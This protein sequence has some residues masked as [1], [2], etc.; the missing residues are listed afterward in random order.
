MTETMSAAVAPFYAIHRKMR[1]DTRRYVIAIETATEA[2]RSGR[3]VPLAKW[4]AGFGHELHLHHTVEDEHFFPALVE[5]MPGGRRRAGRPRARPRRRGRDPQAVG[6][7]RPRPRRS[8]VD[9]ETAH[10]EVLAMAVELRDLLARHLDIEDA[11]IVPRFDEAFTA[12]EL[13]A[14]DA[15]VK[16]S[17]PKKGLS[18]ALPWNV[19]AMDPADPRRVDPHGA[20]HPAAAVPDPRPPLRAPRG[21]RLRRRARAAPRLILDQLGR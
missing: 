9:F 15:Q 12:E 5:R 18:F 13:E 11:E 8:D 10:A 17:L 1:I 14:I 3:L 20:V 4:A 7:G 21:R 16:R 6:P 19:E 2:D